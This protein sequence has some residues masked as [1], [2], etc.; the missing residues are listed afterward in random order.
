MAP[1][2][3]CGAWQ[4]DRAV[5]VRA[6]R[7]VALYEPGE[8]PSSPRQLRA[9]SPSTGA[10]GAPSPT[11]DLRVATAVRGRT[12]GRAPDARRSAVR[13]NRAGGG[14]R[15]PA[16]QDL[17]PAG[18]FSVLSPS[19]SYRM[20]RGDVRIAVTL[21][22]EVCKRRNYQTNKSKRNNPERIS[23]RKYCKWCKQHTSHRETR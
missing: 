14:A 21:A 10:G 23:L 11:A 3:V 22:C 15:Y 1:R 16:Q 12:V 2:Q 19:R 9:R 7:A 8:G 20:A 6:R 5:P 17:H 4:A 13:L 18:R